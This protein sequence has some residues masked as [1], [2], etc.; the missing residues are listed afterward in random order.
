MRPAIFALKRAYQAT[1][2]ALNEGLACYGLTLAQ[3]DVLIALQGQ[4]GLEQRDLQ[5]RLGVTSATLTR[6]L[7][8][9]VSRQLVRRGPS[10]RDARVNVVAATVQ[11]TGV[12][13]ELLAREEATFAA[14][15]AAG[16]APDDLR[17]L[18]RWLNRIAQN[19]GDTSRRIYDEPAA[20]M[21]VS[22][23]S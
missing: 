16:L 14:R 1:E 3:L 20:T 6:V 22:P 11:G 15:F 13:A 18:T 9:M 4:E 12:L 17:C 8:G 10:A 7:D 23:A 5:A 2:K 19:M 21:P